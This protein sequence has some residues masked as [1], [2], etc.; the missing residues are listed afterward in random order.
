MLAHKRHIHASMQALFDDGLVVDGRK[1]DVVVTLGGDM[2]L[3][4]G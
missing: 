4:N 1:Y 3:L 2:K